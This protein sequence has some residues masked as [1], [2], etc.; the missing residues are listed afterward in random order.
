MKH[1]WKRAALSSILAISTSPAMAQDSDWNFAATFY[2]FTPET[3]IGVGGTEATLSFKEALENLDMA[4]MGA[5][6]ASN[7]RWGFLADYM[8]T[9]LSFGNDTP[10]P[11]FSGLN[12]AMKTRIFNGYAT[13]RVY[14]APTVN[15]DLAAGFRWFSAKTDMTLLPGLS[16]GRTSSVNENW[17]DPVIG[18]R[19]QFEL[20][21]K[22]S[23]TAFAD[24]GGFSSD[25][26]TWQVLLTADY[27]INEN[28]AARVGYRHIVVD[29]DLNGTAFSFDQSGPIFG[30]AYRF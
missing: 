25:S 20:S 24:Y 19:A 28:W 3:N 27:E 2:L 17:V 29:H 10:G 26:E 30:V 15:L 7:G 22:W 21:E 23:G 18:V 13:Y 9:D 14:Q 4:F 1:S 5:F 16:P 11:A 8:M 6:E 12:T